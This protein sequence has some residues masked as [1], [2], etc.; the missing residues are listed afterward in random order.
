[1]ISISIDMEIDLDGDD[2]ENNDTS[3]PDT[4]MIVRN[5]HICMVALRINARTRPL[6]HLGLEHACSLPLR[7]EVCLTVCSRYF[8][9]L[10]RT[11]SKRECSAFPVTSSR[12]PKVGIATAQHWG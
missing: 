1:M 2:L 4:D 12:S 10:G 6:T 7:L 3:A 8:Y 5:Q 9:S 11:W